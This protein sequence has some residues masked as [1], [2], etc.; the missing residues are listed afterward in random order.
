MLTC[1]VVP[2]LRGTRMFR[3]FLET[4]RRDEVRMQANLECRSV[5]DTALRLYAHYHEQAMCFSRAHTK[6]AESTAGPDSR[7]RCTVML[8]Q[9]TFRWRGS[10]SDDIRSQA[11]RRQ[12]TLKCPE[13]ANQFGKT[14]KVF[15]HGRQI[16]RRTQMRSCRSS[17][18]W[19][20][21]RPWPVIVSSRH[22]G[23]SRGRRCNG[24]TPAQCCLWRPAVR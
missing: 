17:W 16:P 9:V 21:R 15:P 20:S 10:A 24:T 13:G 23:H 3:Y 5:F 8:R 1:G 12:S 6:K 18:A 7:P 11:C 4:L 19:R 2:E 14:V 22:S